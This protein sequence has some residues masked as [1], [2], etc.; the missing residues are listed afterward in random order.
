[1][2]RAEV[3]GRGFWRAWWQPRAEY[4]ITNGRFGAKRFSLSSANIFL[5]RT[6]EHKQRRALSLYRLLLDA[7]PVR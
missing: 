3:G 4:R 1:M 5:A 7:P 6:R 2:A